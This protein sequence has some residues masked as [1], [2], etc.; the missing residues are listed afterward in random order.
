[1]IE[2]VSDKTLEGKFLRKM[3]GT[4]SSSSNFLDF[5]NGYRGLGKTYSFQLSE[6]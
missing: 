5:G 6:D 3:V 2:A 4:K 1:M